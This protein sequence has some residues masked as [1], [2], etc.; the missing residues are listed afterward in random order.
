VWR[1]HG[2]ANL[3]AGTIQ[4]GWKKS[5]RPVTHSPLMVGRAVSGLTLSTADQRYEINWQPVPTVGMIIN[6]AATSFLRM[7]LFAA[8]P[9]GMAVEIADVRRDHIF[10]LLD[11]YDADSI[12]DPY[13]VPFDVPTVFHKGSYILFETGAGYLA[14]D[15]IVPIQ[16]VP[17]GKAA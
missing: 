13:F 2:N 17:E 6:G 4:I 5:A 9:D 8:G 15:R 16:L 3:S 7:R 10:Q 12:T 1:F 14:S 11:P